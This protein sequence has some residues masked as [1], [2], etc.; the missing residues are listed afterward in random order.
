MAYT[1]FDRLTPNVHLHTPAHSSANGNGPIIVLCTWMAAHPKLVSRYADRFVAD[2]PDSIIIL[3]TS[4]VVDFINLSISGWAERV[5]PAV[6]VLL[7]HPERAVHGAIYSN[8]G[9]NA[10][11]QLAQAYRT[12]THTPLGIGKL[13]IDSAPGSPEIGVS[14]RAMML[15][16]NPPKLIWGL[17]SV[18]MWIYLVLYWIYM[19][20]SGVENPIEGVRQRLNDTALLKEGGERVYVYSKTDQLVPWE[21][22]EASARQAA[23][24]GWQTRLEEFKGSKHVA[25]A[26]VDKERYWKLIGN[27]LA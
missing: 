20:L 6:D 14:H 11:I 9:A 17:A 8:G 19:A 27:S 1:N 15:S 18:L 10:L 2:L 4:S 7:A 24:R 25:H 21:W 23:Q 12:K 26:V 3:I 16:T 13:I 5:G 22:V